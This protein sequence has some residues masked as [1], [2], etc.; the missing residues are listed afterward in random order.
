MQS[1]LYR[2]ARKAGLDVKGHVNLS[3][4]FYTDPLV[5]RVR[6]ADLKR[7]H[8]TSFYT[9][10]LVRRVSI[11]GSL[12]TIPIKFLYR[13]ARKAGPSSSPT[14]SIFSSFYTDPLVRRVGNIKITG[15]GVVEFLYRPARKA[16][17]IT[18]LG[19]NIFYVFLYR[20]ARKAGHYHWYHATP[21][22][23]SIQTRS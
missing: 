10:P 6:R 11:R 7:L 17:H 3:S 16:G 23:V 20:P 22:S 9:D 1:F 12:I 2:P 5:R 8:W 19:G 13:P 18:K 14:G 15:N 4:C 21:L